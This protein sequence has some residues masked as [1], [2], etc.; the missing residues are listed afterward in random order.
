MGPHG[1]R[2]LDS[3]SSLGSTMVQFQVVKKIN[4][5]VICLEYDN[6]IK[7]IVI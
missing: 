6:M 5:Y 3:H 4:N 1:E 2:W 7:T